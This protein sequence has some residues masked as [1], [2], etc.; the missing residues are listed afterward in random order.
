MPDFVQAAP[1][2][3]NR[4]RG[5]AALRRA[6]TRLLPAEVLEAATPALDRM[7]ERAAG[8]LRALGEQAEREPP[9]HVAFDAWG[10]R[11]DRIEVSPAFDRLVAIGQEEGLVALPYEAPYGA[12][13]RIVQAAL[14]NLFD[15]VSAVASCPLTMSDGAAT[16]LTKHDPA[17]AARYVPKLTART[18]GWTSGQWMTEREGGSDVSRTSTVAL[19]EEDGSFRLHGTKFFTSATSADMAL[20]LARPEGAPGGSGGLSL[21]L[22][23][24]RRQDGSWNNIS[25]RRLKE[26]MGTKALPTAELTLEGTVAVPVG[27]LGRGVA[28]VA[29]LLNVARLWA[30]MAGPAAVG[31]LLMLARDYASRREVFGAPLRDN[32]MHT[33]WL[34]NIAVEYEAMLALCF[35]TAAAVGRAEHGGNSTMARLLTP[36]AKLACARGGITYASELIE[37]FGGAGYMEDT[38]LPAIFRNAHVHAIWEG[39]TNVLAHDVLRALAKRE[40]AEEWLADIEARLAGT[41]DSAMAPIRLRVEQAAATLS[42][43]VLD[44]DEKDARR[45][46]QGM[47]RV[48]QAALLVEATQAADPAARAAADLFTRAPLVAPRMTDLPLESFV[49]GGA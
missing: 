39:T 36:L 47:A 28:K 22:L 46:A 5:D 40:L 13:T 33:G 7:G 19:P 37:S 14:M 16:L 6:L 1:K 11:V 3:S 20:A 29:S 32:A 27:G 24:L 38:G 35:E 48:T 26:K 17:L 43:L 49:Y 12:H 34:A 9:R 15:P 25:V 44:P 23:E 31:H 21:F 4:F 45:T 10:R 18:G 41:R 8:E 2:A 30:S 42:P